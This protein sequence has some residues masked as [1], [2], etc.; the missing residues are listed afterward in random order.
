MKAIVK[1]YKCKSVNKRIVLS[2]VY[3]KEDDRHII[4]LQTRTLVDFKTRHILET[5]N[6]YSFETF[7]LLKELL[8]LVLDDGKNKMFIKDLKNI[9]K[10]K[11]KCIEYKHPKFDKQ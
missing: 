11:V 5:N 8:G 6:A 7:V 9:N 10:L 1:Q 3:C 2:I 4:L